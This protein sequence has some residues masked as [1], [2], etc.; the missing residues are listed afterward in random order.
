[1]LAILFVLSY[2]KNIFSDNY[3]VTGTIGIDGQ[4]L[5]FKFEYINQVIIPI[6][7]LFPFQYLTIFMLLVTTIVLAFNWRFRNK[8]VSLIFTIISLI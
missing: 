3:P 8:P 6:Q 1:M 7:L 2:L 4:K 5:S